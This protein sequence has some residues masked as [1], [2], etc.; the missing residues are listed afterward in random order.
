MARFNKYLNVEVDLRAPR[1][2]PDRFDIL[3]GNAYQTEENRHFFTS[4]KKQFPELEKYSDGDIAKCIEYL[5]HKTAQEVVNNRNGV[6]LSDGL[7]IIVAGACKIKTETAANNLD[8]IASAE[9]GTAIPHTNLHSDVYIAKVKYSNDLDKH[10][11]DNHHMWA[12]DAERKLART[13]SAE[14][15]NGNHK[16]YIVFTTY[17]HIAHLFR[18]Q[19]IG[20]DNV[21]TENKRKQQ[22]DQYDEFAF[23]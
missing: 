13:V 9:H 22:L 19:K 8:H 20:K 3:N 18:K 17:Q 1:F 15:K 4:M 6:R 21:K 7:G 5:N 2:R 12:F 23:N 14:F 16:N 10:M 11:F